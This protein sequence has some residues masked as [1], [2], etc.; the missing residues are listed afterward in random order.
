MA[1]SLPCRRPTPTSGGGQAVTLSPT[2]DLSIF[3]EGTNDAAASAS[4]IASAVATVS[5]GVGGKQLWLRPLNGT[6]AANLQSAVTAL[7]NPNVTYGDTTGLWSTA[8]S[9]DGLHPYGYAHLGQIA[10][11]V[12]A[13]AMPLL[14]PASGP[15][16]AQIQAD[17]QAALTAAALPSATVAALHADSQWQD[18]WSYAAGGFTFSA[19]T[20]DDPQPLDRPQPARLLADAVERCDHG[21]D[22]PRTRPT[23]DCPHDHPLGARPM[24]RRPSLPLLLCLCCLAAPA[25]GQAAPGVDTVRH[26]ALE[27]SLSSGSVLLSPFQLGVPVDHPSHLWIGTLTGNVQMSGLIGASGPQGIPGVAGSPGTAA[28]VAVGSVS[29]G[30]VGSQATVTNSGTTSAAVLN[31]TF[32]SPA[33]GAAGSNGTNGTSATVAIGSTATLAAGQS[34]TVSNSGTTSAAILNFGIP[35]GPQGIQGNPGIQGGVGPSGPN[36]PLQANGTTIT[37]TPSFLSFTSPLIATASGQG[38]TVG[39]T[40]TSAAIVSALGYTPQ[41]SGAYITALTGDVTASGPGSASAT[42]ASVGTAGTYA[43]I[44]SMTTDAKGRVTAVTAGSAPASYTAG[45]GVT[46]SGGAISDT[47]AATAQSANTVY[48]GPSSGSAAVPG[49]RGLVSADLPQSP[50]FAGTVTSNAPVGTNAFATVGGDVLAP[51]HTVGGRD[52]I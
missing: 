38:V 26:P 7:G 2:P 19:G 49:F 20:E 47:A 41:A 48:A 6:Q 24:P 30:A 28:T 44:A 1:T 11:G 33:Q 45:T 18:M 21:P 15:T 23:R 36:Y 31:F 32:P 5:A 9:S 42:L 46:I 50:A 12:A 51:D 29:L 35:A 17:V 25:W 40:L 37:S 14:H 16:D 43:Y 3:E 13:I 8:D 39:Y 34:A 4:S 22:G 27:S 52:Q 10:P